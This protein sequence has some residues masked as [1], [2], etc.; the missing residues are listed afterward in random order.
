VLS[1]GV[2]Y[3]VADGQAHAYDARDGSVLWDSPVIPGASI[4]SAGALAGHFYVA[5][6]YGTVVAYRLPL[7]Q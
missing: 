7:S 6:H 1:N 3:Y 5:N 2:L 4:G